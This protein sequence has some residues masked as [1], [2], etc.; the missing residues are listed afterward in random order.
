M[1]SANAAILGKICETAGCSD[2]NLLPCYRIQIDSFVGKIPERPRFTH[3][4]CFPRTLVVLMPTATFHNCPLCLN[5]SNSTMKPKMECTHAAQEACYL[6]SMRDTSLILLTCR[7]GM[8][9]I[10]QREGKERLTSHKS[11]RLVNIFH[12]I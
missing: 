3:N 4:R 7:T 1:M 12:Y 11:V 9:M 10:L 6:K 5:I 2:C 8:H